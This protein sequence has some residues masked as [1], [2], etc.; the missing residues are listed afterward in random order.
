MKKALLCFLSVLLI[1]TGS[2]YAPTKAS[3]VTV[4]VS[5]SLHRGSRG[6]EVTKLQKKLK[7]TGYYIGK[8]D[9][10]YGPLTQKAVKAFQRHAGIKVDGRAGS[11]T[12]KKL[13]ASQSKPKSSVSV[14]YSNVGGYYS[15][16]LSRANQDIVRK[17]CRK[18]NVSFPLALAVM[19]VES[20]YDTRCVC[21]GN[22]GI[23]Q[24]NQC[25]RKFLKK[26]VGVSDLLDIEQ[27]VKAGVYMLS[28]YTKKHSDIH[29]VLMCYN[30]G[31]GA[32]AKKWKKG[33]Y[34]TSYSR[35]VVN[36]L[37]KLRRA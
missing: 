15:I 6:S 36:E 24:I 23:M 14:K 37:N 29:K 20:G 30:M 31:E 12:Q 26:A 17:Y 22:Y 34:S 35:K 2:L 10:H 19:K 11:Q 1:L 5:V 32:A 8:I 27:N 21:K 13:Y 4:S 16:K 18:Y 25:N 3:A 7:S 9:G 28:R 33:I